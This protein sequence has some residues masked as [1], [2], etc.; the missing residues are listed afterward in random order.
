MTTRNPNPAD[1]AN[2]DGSPERQNHELV[3]LLWQI[4]TAPLANYTAAPPR[5]ES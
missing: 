3:S 5:R 1:E 2:Q 4:A